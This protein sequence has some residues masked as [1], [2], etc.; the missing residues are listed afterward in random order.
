MHFFNGAKGVFKVIRPINIFWRL[1]TGSK[2]ARKRP[3]V[4]YI[5]NGDEPWHSVKSCRH[6]EPSVPDSSRD[7]PGFATCHAILGRFILWTHPRVFFE[8]GG[9][10]CKGEGTFF[11]SGGSFCNCPVSSLTPEVASVK[12]EVLSFTPEVA[13]VIARCLLSLRTCLL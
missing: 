6:C 1:I 2:K 12:V 13:S 11:Y 3:E 8:F 5:Q 9:G 7:R 4:Y 10:F